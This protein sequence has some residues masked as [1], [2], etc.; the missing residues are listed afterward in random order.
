MT[1][2][3]DK[4]HRLRV[5]VIG[6]FLDGSD[7]LLIHQMT[8]PEPDCW[9]LPGGGLHPDEPLLTGLRR[10]ILE[11][12]GIQQFQVDEL[13]TVVEEFFPWENDTALHTLNVV[14]RCS[15]HPRPTQ[16]HSE[17]AEVGPR[18]IQWVAIATLTP[19]TCSTRTWKALK[20]AGMV[21]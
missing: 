13:L 7:V 21:E 16:L 2:F 18:G 19:Q 15:A 5:S 17:E 20:V 6:L 8:P 4:P 12:T 14:Y 11:E 10:E 3:P 1:P 9:D